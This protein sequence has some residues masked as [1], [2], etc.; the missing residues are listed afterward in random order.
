MATPV[1]SGGVADLLQ[2]QPSLTP[3]Q[4]KALIM[5]TAYKTFPASSTA[6][7]PVSK[8]SYVSYYDIF[9]VGAGYLGLEAALQNITIV[10]A[11]EAA[12]SPTA[13]YD[14]AFGFVTLSFGS[15]TLWD[16]KA[17][18]GTQSVWGVQSIWG[19]KA[20]WGTQGVWGTKAVWGTQAVSGAKS[21]LGYP[22]RVGRQ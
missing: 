16:T 6:V 1:V 5:M 22:I 11:G 3:D 14:G 21:S 10:P 18:W 13:M 15:S 8:L 19:A 17:V 12:L 9:T 7:D 2:A 20:V 4:V